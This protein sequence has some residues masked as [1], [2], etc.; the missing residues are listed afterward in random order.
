LLLITTCLSIDCKEKRKTPRKF[1]IKWGKPVVDNLFLFSIYFLF[2][3]EP[4]GGVERR[5][6]DFVV[7]QMQRYFALV[8]GRVERQQDSDTAVLVRALDRFHRRLQAVNTLFHH[9]DFARY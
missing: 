6:Q 8:R 2:R 3:A 5:L 9:S 7:A 1:F 4:D